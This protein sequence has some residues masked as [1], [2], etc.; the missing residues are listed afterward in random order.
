MNNYRTSVL[1]DIRVGG[2]GISAKVPLAQTE[3]LMGSE[4]LHT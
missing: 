1:P 4:G 2:S 3:H